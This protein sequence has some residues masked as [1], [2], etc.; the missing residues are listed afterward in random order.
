[1]AFCNLTSFLLIC[2]WSSLVTAEAEPMCSKFAYEKQMIEAMV[3]M[4]V[5]M[6][7][8]DKER[9]TFEENVLSTLEL[10]KEEING[11]L[12]T[13][14]EQIEV[15]MEKWDKEKKS[16]EENVL[17]TLELRKEEMNGLFDDQKLQLEKLISEFN[18]F[19][20]GARN[21]TKDLQTLA[22]TDL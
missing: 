3:R 17:S 21:Q 10:R 5:K 19:R 7:Q 12:D 13:K 15:K 18:D 9:K 16:F 1:M 2:L 22:G 11:V 20:D 6:E 8:W 4:E 14:K